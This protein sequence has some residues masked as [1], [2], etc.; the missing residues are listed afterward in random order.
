MSSQNS[1][2]EILMLNEMILGGRDFEGYQV[3]RIALLG[4]ELLLF[5]HEVMSGSLRPRGLQQARLLVVLQARILELAA[6]SFSRRIYVLSTRNTQVRHSLCRRCISLA[7]QYLS[8][9]KLHKW[10]GGKSIILDTEE[11][12]FFPIGSAQPAVSGSHC[13]NDGY[14]GDKM[15]QIQ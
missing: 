1:Y 11:I 14:A 13:L 15:E 3:R 4:G 2:F 12:S 5:R 9:Y 10:Q 6:I 8:S 7:A